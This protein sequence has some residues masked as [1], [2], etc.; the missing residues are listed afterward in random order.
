[1]ALPSRLGFGIFL[2]PFH[3][4]FDNPTLALQRDL[5]LLEWLDYL[6]YDMAWIGEHHSCGWET[7]ASPEI[8]IAAAAERTK[9]IR[10]GTG[11]IPLPYHHPLIVANR[12]VLLD[13]LTRGRVALGVGPGA[14]NSDGHMLGLD[15]QNVRRR[16]E[17]SLDVIMRLLTEKEPFSH[18]TDWFEL[19]DAH[20]HLRPY[21]QPHFEVAVASAQSPTGMKLAGKHGATPL[22]L[23]FARSPGGFYHNTLED[24]WNI[25]VE[26]GAQHGH[27]MKRE[28]WGLVMHVFLADTRKEA[29]EIARHTAGLLQREY[30]ENTI[31][32]APID[33][34]VDKI[35]DHM[36]DEGAWCIGTPD[37][38]VDAIHRL[39]DMSGGFGTLILLATE[40]GTREQVMHSYELIARYVM[41]K[42]QGSLESLQMSQ[43]LFG[44]MKEEL[45]EQR[46]RALA[47]AG[48]DYE[49]A[50]ATWKR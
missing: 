16:M 48:T 41:P 6:G 33:A 29:M 23:T 13:H 40:V 27:E 35:I 49:Q 7:I 25:A 11:V 9:R 34:P 18:K 12:M 2:A 47:L 39:D 45:A 22:S 10:L 32:M 21:T 46:E 30:F 15:H 3:A 44:G 28:D 1:M 19:A 38:L 36:V 50:R 14:L 20:L 37:D 4:P 26:T 31:G 8:F 17:E 42:F 24:L 5:E 43:N